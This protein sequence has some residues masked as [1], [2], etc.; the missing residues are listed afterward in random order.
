MVMDRGADAPVR[1]LPA[2]YFGPAQVFADRSE[3]E[4]VQR[5]VDMVRSVA[6]APTQP[7]YLISACRYAG[8]DGLYTRDL[9][10][11][12]AYR[13]KLSRHG[14]RFA[15]DPFVRFDESGSL[16]TRDWGPIA[17]TF[18][19]TGPPDQEHSGAIRTSGAML[20]F[21]LAEHRLGPLTAPEL[22][23]LTAALSDAVGLGAD[24]PDAIRAALEAL[25]A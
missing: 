21:L 15:D 4:V 3:T 12:S 25:D 13:S 24:D 23:A 6:A 20:T 8:R 19:V 17:P 10:N 22:N 1:K 11:R 14:M 18:V 2:L 9:F 7:T 16:R 5:L